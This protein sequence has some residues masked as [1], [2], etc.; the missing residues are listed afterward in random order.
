MDATKTI[1]HQAYD[2]LCSAK[3]LD[4]GTYSP[5]LVISKQVWPSR[6]RTIAVRCGECL[7]AEDAMNSAYTQG[8]EWVLN[9]G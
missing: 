6:P 8:V 3:P 9:Y 4:N 2:L 5:M 1:R 7:T